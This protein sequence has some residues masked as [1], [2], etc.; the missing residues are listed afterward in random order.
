MTLESKKYFIT[1][2]DTGCGKSLVSAV[3]VERLEADYWKPVQAGIPTDSDYVKNLVSKERTIHQEAICLTTPMSPH[4]AA[5]I[6][7]SQISLSNIK[8]PETQE[9]LA[10][11][12]AGGLMVPLNQEDLM[13]DIAVQFDADI[14]LVSKNYL[15]SI[16]HTLL[17]VE[18]LKN[19]GVKIAGIIFNGDPNR[20][21]ED[22][23]LQ[24]TGLSCLA[25]I[26]HLPIINKKVVKEL[27]KHVSIEKCGL[28]S[29]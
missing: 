14:I 3:L 8:L 27:S 15:G 4:A 6:E 20:T 17:S 11:E 25:K 2:I 7:N 22:Y 23:I 10:I 24:Y 12:G 29:I 13:I 21:T 18:F 16:N 5:E 9:T 1:G 28:D 26:S 19:K